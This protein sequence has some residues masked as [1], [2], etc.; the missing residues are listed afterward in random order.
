MICAVPGVVAWPLIAFMVAVI[1]ARYVL[2]DSSA[3]DRY[4]NNTLA[5]MLITELLSQPTVQRLLDWAALLN[6]ATTQ[7][8]SLGFMIPACTEFLGFTTL[9]SG[10]SEAET[11][12]AYLRYRWIGIVCFVVFLA[13]ATGARRAHERLEAYPGWDDLLAW[14]V[15]LAMLVVLSVQ[16][17]RMCIAE[18]VRGA[19]RRER[20]VAAA[21]IALGLLIGFATLEALVLPFTNKLGLTNTVRV[22]EW[23][24][25]YNFFIE[26]IGASMLAAIPFVMQ[27]LAYC[28][29]E[30]VS[31]AWRNLQPL[32]ASMRD[33]VPGSAFDVAG[34]ATHGRRRTKLQLHQTTV[35]IR[36]AVLQLR[37]YFGDISDDAL[38]AFVTRF[39]VPSRQRETARHA[40]ALAYAV[41]NKAAGAKP[42]TSE[43]S[44]VFASR[45]TTLDQEIQDLLKLARWWTPAQSAATL[46][47]PSTAKA[48]N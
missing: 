33:A 9:W 20:R 32:R 6:V 1:V 22:Q 40:L 44:A 18:L 30:P 19:T 14:A 11:R 10:R 36:D 15:Y 39:H 47:T 3:F 2:L 43:A 34:V 21:G 42:R 25:G 29:L 24:H 28:G 17:L 27:L 38:G 26:A 37:P 16:L 23:F 4:L 12:K 7:Q 46:L 13:L 45:A 31:R 8:L 41:N 35:E 5:Y 48:M